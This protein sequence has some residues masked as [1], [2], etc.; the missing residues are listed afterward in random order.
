MIP[1]EKYSKVVSN[2]T[3][4][5][6]HTSFFEGDPSEN[7]LVFCAKKA[8]ASVFD[9]SLRNLGTHKKVKITFRSLFRVFCYDVELEPMKC[10]RCTEIYFK[11]NN[12]LIYF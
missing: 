11:Y 3:F 4:S 7:M 2:R 10:I 5:A 9:H 6:I 8:A 1:N 12:R